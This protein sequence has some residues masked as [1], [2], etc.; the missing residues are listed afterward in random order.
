MLSGDVGKYF[1]TPDDQVAVGHP[2]G[3]ALWPAVQQVCHQD[4][5]N[6][7]PPF[8]TGAKDVQVWKQTHACPHSVWMQGKGC[9]VQAAMTC[10]MYMCQYVYR[11]CIVHTFV[12]EC[13]HTRLTMCPVLLCSQVANICLLLGSTAAIDQPWQASGLVEPPWPDE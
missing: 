9:A 7:T 5:S 4:S 2:A 13:N 10:M 3:A 11:T 1:L 12:S 6:P 8:T